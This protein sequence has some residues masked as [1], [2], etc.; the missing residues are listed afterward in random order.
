MED[1]EEKASEQ[2]AVTNDPQFKIKS[3]FMLDRL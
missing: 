3:E 2:A 1:L